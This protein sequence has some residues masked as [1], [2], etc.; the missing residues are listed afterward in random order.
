MCRVT[1]TTTVMITLMVVAYIA[2]RVDGRHAL[3]I[4]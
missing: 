2:F 4:Y 1:E 3:Q